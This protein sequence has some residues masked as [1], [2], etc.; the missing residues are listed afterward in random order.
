[1]IPFR[2]L[3]PDEAALA[4]SRWRAVQRRLLPD[5]M[6]QRAVLARTVPLGSLWH[7]AHRAG[8]PP[9]WIAQRIFALLGR[10]RALYEYDINR[11]S[12]R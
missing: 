6:A 5:Y 12:R 7:V 4:R 11:R 8:K 3:T 10:N 2:W 9:E 1:M